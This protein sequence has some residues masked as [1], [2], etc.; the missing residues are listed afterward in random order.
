LRAADGERRA[1]AREHAKFVEFRPT[2]LAAGDDI[3]VATAAR[4]SARIQRHRVFARA[5]QDF[6][7]IRHLPL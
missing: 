5:N 4:Q 6:V 3:E 1:R 2:E 7:P